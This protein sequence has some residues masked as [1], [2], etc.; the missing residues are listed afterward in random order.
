MKT[1]VLLTG[2]GPFP[3]VAENASGAL[4]GRLGVA[5]RKR[6]PRVIFHTATLPT[7]WT[8]GPERAR[9]AIERAAPDVI[10]HFGVSRKAEGFVVETRGAN[11][12]VAVAD[13][14]GE[15]PPLATL[16]TDGPRFRP[17]TLPVA[18]IV[19]RLRVLS[20]PVITS[21]DAGSYLCN[22]VLFQT[23]GLT[24]KSKT[25]AGFIH[26][27]VALAGSD[28]GGALT[29]RQALAGS[30]EIIAECLR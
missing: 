25:M 13:G 19:A 9:R 6:W 14:A 24:A 18:A 1:S 11:A 10:V 17:A 28:Q 29:S 12:C 16:E 23:L 22:A 21:D 15:L 5:A 26:I 20:L 7:E 8:I 3:G 2:F 4:V 27:P 30:L